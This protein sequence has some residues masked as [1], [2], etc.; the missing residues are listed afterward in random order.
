MPSWPSSPSPLAARPHES[1]SVDAKA[2]RSLLVSARNHL[3]FFLIDSRT[4]CLVPSEFPR[5]RHG[6]RWSLLPSAHL[7][8]PL[9]RRS[10]SC[11]TRHCARVPVE[12]G[13]RFL[14]IVRFPFPA[15][16]P[17]A[18]GEPPVAFLVMVLTLA[19]LE[20]V[21]PVG[22]LNR[23]FIAVLLCFR[24]APPVF[25]T[26]ASL[27]VVTVEFLSSRTPLRFAALS[28]SS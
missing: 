8:P 24:Q 20:H 16:V 1:P 19:P 11:H 27:R 4:I 26:T 25:G 18:T 10:S 6:R 17:I 28:W 21:L 9:G 12:K 3:H 15:T 23:A 13:A 7:R 14:H 5:H 22:A 2:S